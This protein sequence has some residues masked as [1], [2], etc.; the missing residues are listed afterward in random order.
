MRFLNN[1]YEYRIITQATLH[2]LDSIIQGEKTREKS[3]DAYGLGPS[4]MPGLSTYTAVQICIQAHLIMNHT[5]LTFNREITICNICAVN[6][7][8][9]IRRIV[10]KRNWL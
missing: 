4:I 5:S 9:T 7:I 6:R 3:L 2:W 1:G 10:Q 8:F